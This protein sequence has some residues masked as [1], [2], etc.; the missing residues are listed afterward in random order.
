M[1]K[2]SQKTDKR[3]EKNRLEYRNAS[4]IKMYCA[5]SSFILLRIKYLPSCEVRLF[6]SLHVGEL[7]I[8][9]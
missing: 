2:F 7:I 8:Y 9:V 3:I 6:R 1:K 4:D 5:A